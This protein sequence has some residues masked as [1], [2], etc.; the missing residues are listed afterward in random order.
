MPDSLHWVEEEKT[1]D[2][3]KRSARALSKRSFSHTTL[4]D[5]KLR[6]TEL[7]KERG[8]LPDGSN[9]TEP[10]TGMLPNVN[11]S[12]L[13]PPDETYI[14]VSS[15]V[16]RRILAQHLQNY[17]V[18][19]WRESNEH[20]EGSSPHATQASPYHACFSKTNRFLTQY[21]IGK[22]HASLGP[23][24]KVAREYLAMKKKGGAELNSQFHIR[25]EGMGHELWRKNRM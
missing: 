4:P 11:G 16:H 25:P 3:D 5:K 19:R 7:D 13:L 23:R 9:V 18:E 15:E 8:S 17:R 14:D 10:H 2:E 6:R 20:L 22:E 1:Q 24:S 21:T 12:T